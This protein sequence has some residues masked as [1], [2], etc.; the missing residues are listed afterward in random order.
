MAEASPNPEQAP[1][2]PRR[3]GGLQA[4]LPTLLSI[5]LMPV[6]A[7]VLT[8][9]VLLP[10]L[11]QGLGAAAV[12][13][14]EGQPE[15]PHAAAATAAAAA[16]KPKQRIPLNKIIVNVSGSLGTRMLLA[17]VTLA[18][19]HPDLKTRIEENT[20][21][22]RDVA[23]TILGSKTIAD[24]EKPEARNLIRAELLSQFN[25]VLGGEMVSDLYLTEFAIQ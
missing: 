4:W 13:A 20:D 19:T 18:G 14:R 3:G 2:A 12:Q 22:L 24:L 5:V 11:Q 23:A 9:K 7:Y 10:K 6:L 21:Q 1:A 8:L 15:D 17:S 25:T 16:G